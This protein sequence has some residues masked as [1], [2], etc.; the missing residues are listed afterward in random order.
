MKTEELYRIT[1]QIN[2][3]CKRLHGPGLRENISV[4][5]HHQVSSC[6]VLHDKTHVFL[7]LE[8][9]KQVDQERVTDAVDRLK[10]P[11][12]THQTG[13]QTETLQGPN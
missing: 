11:L 1:G 12:L 8:T 9:R 5:V 6:S 10:D 4:D 13:R 7:R 3:K 2:R